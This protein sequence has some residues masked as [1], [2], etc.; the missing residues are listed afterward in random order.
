[1]INTY[2]IY[3]LKVEEFSGL[4][5]KI[6]SVGLVEQKS[7]IYD[8]Y[9]M[10]FYFSEKVEG[11]DI[12]WFETYKEFINVQGKT[13]KNIFHFGLLICKNEDNPNEIYAVSL[14]KSHFYL[15]KFIKPNFGI[16]LAVR[17][18][19]EKT[20]I[21]KKSRYFT[22]TK[23]HEVSSYENFN[24]NSYESGE[25]VEHLKIKASNHE[26]WGDKNIIFADSIQ[27]NVNKSP[28]EL[29]QILNEISDTLNNEEIIK[30]PKLEPV[31][32][33][34]LI[35]VFDSKILSL[36]NQDFCIGV[37]EINISGVNISFRFNEHNYELI[38]KKDRR[39]LANLDLGNSLDD[40]RI[41]EFIKTNGVTDIDDLYLRFK[42]EDSGRFTQ[43]LKEILDFYINHD[44]FHYF[45]KCGKWFKFNETFTEYLKKSLEQ[46]EIN[47]KQDLIECK[48][49][50]W[51]IAKET[52]I[53]EG[54]EIDNKITYREYYF[55]L[56]L[57]NNYGYELLD[58]QLKEIQSL[59]VKA[60]KYKV[61]IA[62]LYKDN[63][64]I[65]VK[66]SENPQDLIYNI[67]QSKSSLELIKQGKISFDYNLES[68]SLWLVL[69]KPISSIIEIN[70]IQFLLALDSWKKHV[71]FFGLKPKIYISKHIKS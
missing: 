14:G 19:D 70:S 42:I 26:I 8:N 24:V 5:E 36:L 63:E 7:Q 43:P 68:A 51:K 52:K 33:V 65:S 67:E 49:L 60:K 27:L 44:G 64:I 6:K 57:C 16:T 40:L 41:S 18:G 53:K 4:L 32:D 38:Y 9:E 58:R 46:L 3:S 50:D 59:N 30:L 61:E 37:E 28:N 17:M 69:E 39:Q 55:N 29:A 47:F 13:P 56:T 35:K 2:N 22:G 34:D 21:L 66:I 23:R 20:T 54:E 71:E 10:T 11:N 31:T 12:W 15:A 48:Y 62:D 45:L 25:S 1:M